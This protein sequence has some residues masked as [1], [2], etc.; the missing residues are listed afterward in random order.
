VGIVQSTVL[1]N[2]LC[3]LEN[4]SQ[5]HFHGDGDCGGSEACSMA[6]VASAVDGLGVA[7]ISM[8]LRPISL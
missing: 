8:D 2:C 7:S 6:E 3:G 1:I 5:R 4:D